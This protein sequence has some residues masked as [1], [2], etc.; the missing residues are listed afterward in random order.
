MPTHYIGIDLGGTNVK[1]GVVDSQGNVAGHVSMPTGSGR[2]DLA[3]DLVIGRMVDAAKQAVEKA[4]LTM[5]DIAAV[6]VLSPGQSSL[7]KGIVYRSAN[8]PWKNV[9]LRAKVS[10]KLGLPAILENDAN[11][12]AYGEWWAG[13][14]KGRN[15]KNLCM[16]TLG[17]GIGGGNCIRGR[18]CAA[19]LI[20]RRSLGT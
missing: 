5:G 11:A 7:R 18:W 2:K 17:T 3:A 16:L 20:L 14:G 12:A 19:S 6:G 15:F 13:V 9:H 10:K 4:G 1:T 8:L